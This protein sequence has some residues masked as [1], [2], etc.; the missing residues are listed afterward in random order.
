MSDATWFDRWATR[1]SDSFGLSERDT[2]AVFSWEDVLT[3]LGGDAE[4]LDRVTPRV[5]AEVRPA[6][7]YARQHLDAIVTLV[8]EEVGRRKARAAFDNAAAEVPDCPH[9]RYGVVQ[10]PH[11]GHVDLV[12]HVVR[13]A[14]VTA[15]GRKQFATAHVACTCRLGLRRQTTVDHKGQSLMT[16]PDYDK[17]N[18][19]WRQQMAEMEHAND[20]LDNARRR[21]EA[22]PADTRRAVFPTSG[23][24]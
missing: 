17:L 15:T 11:L 1:Y 8:V 20:V 16:L 6:P 23:V 22:T 21:L 7:A 13:P 3:S 5:L 9:C 19:Y 4:I 10:V 2:R 14:K 18:P 12:E 24:D